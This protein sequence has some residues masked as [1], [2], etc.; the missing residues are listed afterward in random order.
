MNIYQ[1]ERKKLKLF[2]KEVKEFW[3]QKTEGLFENSR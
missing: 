2:I 3:I 1:F